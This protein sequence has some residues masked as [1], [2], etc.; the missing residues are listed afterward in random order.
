MPHRLARHGRIARVE[1]LPQLAAFALLLLLTACGTLFSDRS[2]GSR[3]HA[4]YMDNILAAEDAR[5]AS[6]PV[7]TQA[8]EEEDALLRRYALRAH[9]RIGDPASIQPVFAATLVEHVQENK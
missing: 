2:P 3:W 1:G 5:D 8:L 6:S 7:L 9:G 4:A